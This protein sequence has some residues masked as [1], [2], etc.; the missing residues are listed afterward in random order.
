M[1]PLEIVAE[2]TDSFAKDETAAQTFDAYD[3]FLSLMN[4][5]TARKQL[6]DLRTEDA[7]TNKT[8][9]QIRSISNHFQ[10]GLNKL[11][12]TDNDKLAQLTRKYGI[13]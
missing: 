1:T 6:A 10:D 9:Q 12:L 8:F 4:D 3:Q 7:R 5:G 2:A 13:F 11:L